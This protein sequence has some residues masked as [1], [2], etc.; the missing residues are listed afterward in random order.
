MN[1]ITKNE[2]INI[3]GEMNETLDKRIDALLEK[4][5]NV[6]LLKLSKRLH[7][8][9]TYIQKWKNLYQDYKKFLN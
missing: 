2:E 5:K 6:K 9:N 1:E 7:C 8:I 3:L 4:E